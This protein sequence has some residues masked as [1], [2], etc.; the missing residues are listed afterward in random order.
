V[1]PNLSLC[2][3]GFKCPEDAAMPSKKYEKLARYFEICG[4]GDL[5]API[6]DP[7][8]TLSPLPQQETAICQEDIVLR[9]EPISG[10]G[11]DVYIYICIKK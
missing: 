8:P 1:T 11:N 5:V 9:D 4:Q 3:N 7:I 10:S 2:S 6:I